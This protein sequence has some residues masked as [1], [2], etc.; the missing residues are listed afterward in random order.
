MTVIDFLRDYKLVTFDK[1]Y[2][3]LLEEHLPTPNLDKLPKQ[4]VIEA[5]INFKT[6]CFQMP[7]YQNL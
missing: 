5:T 1:F 4:E 3:N 6:K 2:L 7:F